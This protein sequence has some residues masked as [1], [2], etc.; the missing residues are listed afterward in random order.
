MK[1]LNP[2]LALVAALAYGLLHAFSVFALEAPKGRV[3]LTISG[4]VQETNSSEGAQFDLAMLEALPQKTFTTLT[5][6]SPKPIKFT[7]PLLRDLL[8]AVKASGQNIHA[9][10][11]NDYQ[12]TM[13]MSDATSFDVIMAHH[14]DDQVI[15]VRTKGPLFIVYP[16]DTLPELRSNI[17]Y[18]RS[19]WQLKSLTIE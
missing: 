11:L 2:K 14:M 10:A 1:R 7:G 3:I 9:K 15:P 6:W 13:P 8:A 16:Y 5:P 19:S 18:S 17:Y 4:K 12:S